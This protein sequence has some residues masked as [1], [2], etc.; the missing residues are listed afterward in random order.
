MRE[1]CTMHWWCKPVWLSMST[2]FR[3]IQVPSGDKW[4][5]QQSM[6]ARRRVSGWTWRLHMWLFAGIHRY[7]IIVRTA[8]CFGILWCWAGRSTSCHISMKLNWLLL[9]VDKPQLVNFCCL[10]L[11]H[12]APKSSPIFTS[13]QQQWNAPDFVTIVYSHVFES[14]S[15]P[16]FYMI[17]IAFISLIHLLATAIYNCESYIYAQNL[18]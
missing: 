15:F 7:D 8:A 2:R 3:G 5:R 9:T 18:M 4:M 11:K 10:T 6:S 13:V 14:L 12:M 17:F 16:K 1:R